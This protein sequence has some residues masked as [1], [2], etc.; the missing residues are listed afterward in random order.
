MYEGIDL[1]IGQSFGMQY[2][3]AGQITLV[4]CL[5]FYLN[6]MRQA[7]L[8]F[9]DSMG[10]FR[11]DRHKAIAEALINLVVS[12]ILG[13]FWGTIGV[14]LGTLVSTVT[15]SLWVEPY[16]LYKHRLEMPVVPYFIRYGIYAGVTFLLWYLEDFLCKGVS[17]MVGNLWLVCLLRVAVCFVVTNVVYLALYFRTDEFRLLWEKAMMLLRKRLGR[18]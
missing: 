13:Y 11:Y 8:I 2:M 6:G 16:M 5:N 3:F 15:T 7:T 10:L 18:P 14:F 17:H 9:R 1:F 12:L 4:L